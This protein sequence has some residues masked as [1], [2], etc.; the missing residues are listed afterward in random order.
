[1]TEAHAYQREGVLR[2]Q[3]RLGNAMRGRTN[4]PFRAPKT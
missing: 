1:M 2:G 3:T 4:V